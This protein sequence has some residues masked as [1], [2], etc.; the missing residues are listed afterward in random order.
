MVDTV[1]GFEQVFITYKDV[2]E[3]NPGWTEEM[4]EDYLSLKRDLTSSTETADLA[5]DTSSKSSLLPGLVQRIKELENVQHPKYG[6][7]ALDQISKD[8]LKS[9]NVSVDFTTSGNQFITCS[10]TTAISL[11][12][13]P[14]PKELEELYIKRKAIGVVNFIGNIDG[15]TNEYIAS[16]G[17]GIHLIYTGAMGY[18][19]AV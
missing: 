15:N 2:R 13:N 7:I 12:L 19:G 3:A 17:D 4:I 8:S 14:Y 16:V 5:T 11:T 1:T 9:V 6:Q 10:N 18:W